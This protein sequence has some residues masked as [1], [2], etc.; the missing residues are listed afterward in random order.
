MG[1]MNWKQSETGSY[2][3]EHITEMYLGDKHPKY[4][5][6][7][8]PDDAG[9]VIGQFYTFT[10]EYVPLEEEGEERLVFTTSDEAKTYI[11]TV[12]EKISD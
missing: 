7:N 9:W 2:F 5:V 8:N 1:N 10:G 4:H 3:S 12:L 11:E 6:L